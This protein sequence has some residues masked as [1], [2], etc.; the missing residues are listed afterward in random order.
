MEDTILQT[1]LEWL[2]DLLNNKL[3]HAKIYYYQEWDVYRL[4]VNS[5]MFGMFGKKEEN[6]ILTLKN[7]PLE[8]DFLVKNVKGVVPGY[9]ANKKHWITIYLNDTE[10]DFDKIE[11]LVLASYKSVVA[12]FNKKDKEIYAI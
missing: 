7:D 11:N 3:V 8:N 12:K 9:Y 2:E 6:I 1:N 4:D 10:L 5:K